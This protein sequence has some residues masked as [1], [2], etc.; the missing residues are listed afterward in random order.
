MLKSLAIIPVT[1]VALLNHPPCVQA[2]AEPAIDVVLDQRVAPVGSE[3]TI[4]LRSEA[5]GSLISAAREKALST[6]KLTFPG[7]QSSGPPVADADGSIRV[8]GRLGR[9]GVFP[10][11]ASLVVDGS[12]MKARDFLVSYSA[13][14][15]AHS[16]HGGYYVFLGRGDHWEPTHQLASWTIADWK[17]LVDFLGDH[18]LDTL[19]VLMNGYTLA[20]PT[21]RYPALRD[22]YSQNAKYN[23]LGG[24]IDYAHSR[25]VKIYLTMTTDD[26]AEGFGQA[27]PETVRIDKYGDPRSARA[28]TLEH[29]LVERYITDMFEEV[30][31]LYPKADGIVIHPTEENPDRFNPETLARFRQ[32]TG[33]DLT[34][35]RKADRFRWYNEQYARFLVRLHTLAMSRNPKMDFVMFNCWWQDEYAEVYKRILPASVR[36]CVWY[37]GWED[38]EST[39]WPIYSWVQLVGSHRIIYMPTGRS[40]MYPAAAWEEVDRHIGTDRLVSTAHALGVTSCVYFAGWNLGTEEDRVRDLMIARFPSA[41][42]AAEPQRKLDLVPRLYGDYFGTRAELLR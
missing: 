16:A 1:V 11:E 37:Y 39:K 2:A 36:F 17:R 42:L 33:G 22:R 27:H 3:V 20:Y 13:D 6:F 21:D 8:A 7:F 40:F 41:S 29:P 30:L 18:H 4:R 34:H 35:A 10:F 23:I 24:M 25:H 28:L 26:H 14:V 15:P 5:F 19:F 12:A 9:P 32:E 38:T 31:A